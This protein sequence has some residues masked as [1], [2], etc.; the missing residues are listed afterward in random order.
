MAVKKGIDVSYAQGNIDFNKI[1][2]KQ[3]DFAIIRS[4]YGWEKNQKDDKCDRNI[5]GFQK[6]G[7]PC[8]IY[9]YSYAKSTEDAVK[10]AKYCIDC[11]KEY[12]IE[13]P[14]FFDIEEN[15]TAKLGKRVC[16]DII[17]AFCDYIK[18]QGYSAGVYVNLNWL[19]NYIYKNEIIGKYDLW[20]AQWGTP[21]P[22]YNCDVWQY[23]VGKAGSI[24]GINGEIDLNYMYK[25][26]KTETETPKK[27]TS[28]SETSTENSVASYKKGD[29]IKVINPIDYDSGK[30]FTVYDNETYTV[31]ESVRDR[32]VIGINGQVTSAVSA[33]NIQKVNVKPSSSK[34]SY[35]YKVQKNDTLS[36]IA[37]K[38]NTTVDKIVIENN[39]KNPDLIFTDQILKITV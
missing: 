10:E 2:K 13:L 26:Y 23:N 39:I 3:I 25:N 17:K 30:K 21:K 5:K 22:L 38:Y 6:I 27:D 14:V 15:S 8:G 33:N 1:D 29:I 12:K 11:I 34:K 37:K 20:L 19:D 7:I 4:S 28:D 9:H 32:V 24:K 36:T 35:T 16:T 31:I 18:S